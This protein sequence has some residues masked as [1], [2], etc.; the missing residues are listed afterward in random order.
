MRHPRRYARSHFLARHESRPLDAPRTTGKADVAV[1]NGVITLIVT[2]LATLFAPP[3]GA[4]QSTRPLRLSEMTSR[5]SYIFAG[6]VMRQSTGLADDGRTV[7]T[8]VIFE[9]LRFAKGS[10]RGDSLTI[11]M[12]GGVYGGSERSYVG[13]PTF[14][15]GTRYIVLASR[16]L[17][18]RDDLYAPVIGHDRGVITV[19]PT[20][21]KG[22][23]ELHDY[24]GR[25]LLGIQ[26][27]QLKVLRHPGA[28]RQ[29]RHNSEQVPDS[30]SLNLYLELP[31]DNGER[32]SE[33]ELLRALRS[34]AGTGGGQR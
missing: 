17:G 22:H 27:G 34:L 16:G 10:S 9:Q 3:A 2:I 20:D 14:A 8:R 23:H 31:T 30:A 13:E 12:Y 18:S 7:V 28:E 15:V 21:A 19:V 26:G 29:K 32:L 11:T 4:S 33:Q 1:L 25:V 6:T 24:R 5:S